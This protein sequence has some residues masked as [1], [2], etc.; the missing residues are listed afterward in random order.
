MAPIRQRRIHATRKTRFQRTDPRAGV[1]D[2]SSDWCRPGRVSLGFLALIPAIGSALSAIC[3]LDVY[4]MKKAYKAG[5]CVG[6]KVNIL[7]HRGSVFIY[8][9]GFCT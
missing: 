1:G 4:L 5:Y 2:Y 6:D 9:G 7:T 8:K 3:F